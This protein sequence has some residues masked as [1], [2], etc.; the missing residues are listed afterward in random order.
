V[1]IKIPEFRRSIDTAQI[2]QLMQP[3]GTPDSPSSGDVGRMVNLDRGTF[4]HQSEFLRAVGFALAS[5][6][7]IF[8]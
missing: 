4:D 8:G 5:K 3:R 1:G 6:E 7:D 2:G